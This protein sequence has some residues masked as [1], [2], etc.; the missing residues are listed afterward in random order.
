[1]K[2]IGPIAI[3]PEI[4]QEITYSPE[5]FDPENDQFPD[6]QVS[7]RR[8]PAGGYVLL[9]ANSRYYP[10]DVTYRIS[11]LKEGGKVRRLFNTNE[12]E[13]QQGAFSDH[14]EFM[15]TRA[16]VFQSDVPLD[17]PV[18]ISVEIVPYPDKTDPVYSAPGLPD[19][20]RPGKKNIMR[21]P[22]FEEAAYSDWPDYY[23]FT[24][25]G[26]MLGHPDVESQYGIDTSKP[27]EGNNCLWIKTQPRNVRF[28]AACSPKVSNLEEKYVLSAYMR[29]DRPGVRVRFVGFGWRVPK[30]TFGYK[31]FTLTTE[32]QAYSE[33]G[34]LIP[35]LPSWHS[36]GVE[37]LGGQD[38]TVFVDALQFEKGTELTEYEP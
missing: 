5:E 19:T 3:T 30:P 13:V 36:V 31:E 32:W 12:H 23:L 2:L 4:A 16:Y 6:I 37:I 38:G 17:E 27:Y 15:G 1:M 33:V 21:N 10:V 22:G 25:G 7:L 26:P 28:Y 24:V 11:L 20:G 29:A 9:A 8:N 14:V 35:G 34:S 18:Q